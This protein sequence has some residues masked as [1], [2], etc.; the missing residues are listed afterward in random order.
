MTEERVNQ[1]M[2]E[3]DSIRK[4]RRE[5]G[6]LFLEAVLENS[7]NIRD[8]YVKWYDKAIDELLNE[9]DLM[10]ELVPYEELD[11]KKAQLETIKTRFD[12][13]KKELEE[14][15][16]SIEKG[17]IKTFDD[18]ETD[19]T[20]INRFPKSPRQARLAVIEAVQIA[21]EIEQIERSV[22]KI[23]TFVRNVIVL[24]RRVSSSS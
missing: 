9:I 17:E 18:L 16:K 24:A 10:N 23:S 21:Q 12:G 3:L 13:N 6:N 2:Q 15:I 4:S 11:A 8:K 19:E 20:N 5:R 7:K 14:F 22:E 1:I